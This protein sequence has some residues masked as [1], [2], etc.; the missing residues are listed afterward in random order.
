MTARIAMLLCPDA[1]FLAEGFEKIAL[2]DGY[3]DVVAGNIQ[4]GN[5]AV[6][7]PVYINSR[8]TSTIH[9]YFLSKSLDKL[10]LDGVMALITS[11]YTMDKRD[12]GVQRYL[13]HRAD[14]IGAIRLPNTGFKANAGI[15][16]TTDI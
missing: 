5:C 6:F 10:Q 7:G 16:V 13:A 4:F 3:F 2:A 11:R 14:F 15:E 8:V 9:D 12:T 1:K